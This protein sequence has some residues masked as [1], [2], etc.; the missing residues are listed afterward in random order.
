MVSDIFFMVNCPKNKGKRLLFL[1]SITLHEFISYAL[2]KHKKV[3]QVH[4]NLRN[5]L[6]RI[7]MN[8]KLLFWSK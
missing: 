8:Y 6:N 5:F 7:L 4:K 3:S 2:I 1:H